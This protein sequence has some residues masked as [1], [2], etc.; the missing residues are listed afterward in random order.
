MTRKAK[1][2]IDGFVLRFPRTGVVNYAFNVI[3]GL[4]DSG[5]CDVEILLQDLGFADQD[6]AAFA[7][8]LPYRLIEQTDFDARQR[9]LLGEVWSHPGLLLP[10]PGT[11]TRNS[12][13]CD[14]YHCTDVYYYPC[15]KAHKN[16]IMVHDLTT[17]LYPDTHEALNIEKE[18]QK[19]AALHDFD[20]IL[21]NSDATKR[22]I[23]RFCGIDPGKIATLYLG[24]D[25]IYDRPSFI[26]RD[27]LVDSIGVP[28]DRRYLLSVS[29]IEPRKNII[30]VLQAFEDLVS[31]TKAY[32]DIVLV[33]AGPSGWNNEKLAAFLADY[34]LQDRVFFTG[35]VPQKL[36]PSLYHFAEAF[37]YL[38]FYEGFGLPLLEAMKCGTPVITSNISSMPEVVGDCGLL[39]DP[40]K[41][42]D[43]SEGLRQLLENQVLSDRFRQSGRARSTQFTWDRHIEALLDIFEVK[44]VQISPARDSKDHAATPTIANGNSKNG[45][46]YNAGPLV[47]E[48]GYAS[49]LAAERWS[50]A[51]QRQERLTHI[52]MMPQ[53][54]IFHVLIDGD[55][56]T[57]FAATVRSCEA[58][59]FPPVSVRPASAL[60]DIDACSGSFLL[61]LRAGHLLHERALYECARRIIMEP[62]V[63]VIY[64]DEDCISPTGERGRPFLK[65]D[66]S[67]DLL[68]A[69][70]YIGSAAC[71][72]LKFAALNMADVKCQYDLLLQ[73]SE[74][75]Q[76]VTHLRQILLHRPD[77]LE[78][79]Q[80]ASVLDKEIDAL[81]RRLVRSGREGLVSAVRPNHAA[82]R[83]Q[84]K[85]R[86][87][88]LVSI[89]IPTAAKTVSINGA[90]RDLIGECVRSIVEKSTYRNI[91]FVIVDNGDLEQKRLSSAHSF[92]VRYVTYSQPEVNISRKM[93]F[94]AAAAA[95]DYLLLLNDDTEV[96]TPD[97]IEK[98]LRHFEKPHVGIVGGK[99]LY[100]D[101]TIQ[102]AG[103]VVVHGHPDHVSRGLS[104][105]DLGSYFSNAIV[106]NYQAVT[107]AMTLVPTN[108]FRDVG[109]YEEGMP[110][111]FN[112]ID[113][114][115][116]IW[117]VGRTVVYDP[118]VELYHFEGKS[119]TNSYN[120][121]DRDAFYKRWGRSPIDRFYNEFFLS[122][123]PADYSFKLNPRF[124]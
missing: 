66:W 29:T 27:E 105:N 16:V 53:P 10:L 79:A 6:L 43:A 41:P 104:Q 60:K 109:G 72:S 12:A 69:A 120:F 124:I 55:E 110:L 93:N 38:S 107:G 49:F 1:V 89:V 84:S 36:M 13:P 3:K 48:E 50:D 17:T 26:S 123:A 94:G 44:P 86:G 91:E 92:P 74:R 122:L 67:P 112:D 35:F 63:D 83:I 4:V 117:H 37:I 88:P 11:T 103:V 34:K 9:S 118:D 42:R 77:T 40:T 102:H 2:L 20:H 113:L 96:I 108:L 54:P 31:R 71:Y 25:A 121:D 81:Q 15:A 56:D 47:G 101:N 58:Q 78:D 106:R 99:L 32:D 70:N 73:C 5:L 39:V 28:R 82:Y 111:T 90:K 114:C 51:V 68:E 24:T 75:A 22:D 45:D 87:N 46:T 57:A 119:A 23:V 116:K 30:G 8:S 85:V 14:V 80:P 76:R 33:L 95:G 64:F 19:L 52:R 62:D 21:A 65:P 115:M 59:L 61:Y 7:K 97:W 18:R 100:P 98:M